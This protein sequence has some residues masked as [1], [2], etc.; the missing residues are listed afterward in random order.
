MTRARKIGFGCLGGLTLAAAALAWAAWSLGLVGGP[1]YRTVASIEGEP[2]YADPL[3]AARARALPTVRAY[4]D[5][6]FAHQPNGS[7]CGPTSVA[8]LARSAGIPLAPA[9]ALEGS[10]ITTIFGVLPGGITL[11]EVAGLV[12][13]ALPESR[14][15]IVRPA[16]ADELRA[17]IARSGEAGVRVLVN[18]HRGPLFGRGGGHHSPV[19]GYLADEDLAVIL[20]TNADY[21]GPWLVD[22]DRLWPGVREIDRATGLP[23]GLVVATLPSD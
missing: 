17:A 4:L 15:E 3:L 16:G 2:A 6:G 21:H 13:R 10:G 1:D 8:N 14:V 12:S 9:A 7:F 20:D 19:G 5:A 22:V 11:D 23:R 18:F